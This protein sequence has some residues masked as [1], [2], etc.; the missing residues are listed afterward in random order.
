MDIRKGME[1]TKAI[2][3]DKTERIIFR[4]EPSIKKMFKNE[5]AARYKHTPSMSA[6]LGN[7][8]IDYILWDEK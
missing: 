4:I 8:I 1:I 3:E 7:L 5:I 2:M 6:V